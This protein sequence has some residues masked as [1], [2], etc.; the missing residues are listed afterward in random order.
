[1]SNSQTKKRLTIESIPGKDGYEQYQGDNIR[2]DFDVKNPNKV[3]DIP[4]K[5]DYL[6]DIGGPRALGGARQRVP[7]EPLPLGSGNPSTIRLDSV[8]I[9]NTLPTIN[10]AN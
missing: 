9:P 1:M 6:N 10:K 7:N 3:L 4:P 8:E 2:V 5:S